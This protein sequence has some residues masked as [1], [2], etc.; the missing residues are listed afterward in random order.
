MTSVRACPGS[1]MRD[2]GF[3]DVIPDTVALII[4]KMLYRDGVLF[5][6]LRSAGSL[7]ETYTINELSRPNLRTMSARRD[8][9]G[10][11]CEECFF[12]AGLYDMAWLMIAWI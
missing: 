2:D 10:T 3:F 6:S 9:R 12:N 5:H 1:K 7:F 8:N 11:A 4:P